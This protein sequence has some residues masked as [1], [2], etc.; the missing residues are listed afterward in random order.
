MGVRKMNFTKLYPKTMRT[1]V[2][3][4][5]KIRLQFPKIQGRTTAVLYMG[6]DLAKRIGIGHGDRLGIFISDSNPLIWLLKRDEIGWTIVDLHKGK[7]KT[8]SMMRIQLV[9]NGEVP[10]GMEDG[11]LKFLDHDFY[12]GGIRIFLPG[13]TSEDKM[14]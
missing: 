14:L 3:L 5:D 2:Y 13:T 12:E 8:H 6:K 7:S 9:W 11:K 10:Y 1:S 4:G